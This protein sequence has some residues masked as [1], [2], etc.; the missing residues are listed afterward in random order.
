[1]SYRKKHIKS[2]IHRI[3]PRKSIFRRL[4]FWIVILFLIIVLFIFYLVLFYPGLQIK[5]IVVSGNDKI[6]TQELQDVIF[7]NA[8]TGL[9]KFWNFQITSKSIFLFNINKIDKEILEKF[10]TIEKVTINKKLPQTIM[11]GVTEREPVGVFC[12]NNNCFLID[13]NGIVFEPLSTN[14]A[15]VLIVRQDPKGTPENGQV[16]TGEDVVAQNIINAISKIQKSLKDNFQIDLKEALVAS[17]VRLNV[18]TSENWQIYFDLSPESD[19]NLQL[20]KL[21]LLLNGGMSADSRKNLRYIDL[22]PQDRAIICDNK[23]CGG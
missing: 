17:S 16:F 12:D 3:R 19:I 11:L 5:N 1:M 20:T 21:N 9:V 6:S 7:N 4:W 23:T 2:K 18:T 10:P 13:N 14:P 15:N 22:R 8:N